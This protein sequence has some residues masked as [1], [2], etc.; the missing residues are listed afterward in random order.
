MS[1]YHSPRDSVLHPVVLVALV[2]WLVN[3]HLLKAAYPGVVTGKLSDVAGLV[4]FPMILLATLPSRLTGGE[5]A[6]PAACACA[7][8]T[9]LAFAAINLDAASARVLTPAFA[10][11]RRLV[12]GEPPG[13]WLGPVRHVTDAEDLLALPFVIVT[14]MIVARRS[15]R[16]SLVALAAVFTAL[17]AATPAHAQDAAA[18]SPSP[19]T[20][21]RSVVRIGAEAFGG[22]T[23]A[24]E[25]ADRGRYSYVLSGMRVGVSAQRGRTQFGAFGTFVNGSLAR[26][27][28][29]YAQFG[30]VHPTYRAFAVG[31]TAGTD[32]RRLR[33]E[34]SLMFVQARY[35]HVRGAA[36]FGNATLRMAIGDRRR[37][38]YSF[39]A[40]SSDGFL[41]DGRLVDQ[42]ILFERD[43]CSVRVAVGAGMVLTPDIAAS[44][45]TDEGW[46]LRASR[47]DHEIIFAIP[48]FIVDFEAHVHVTPRISLDVWVQGGMQWPRGRFGLRVAL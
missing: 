11:L 2:A 45:A 14:P 21:A 10:L 4:A 12:H 17:F 44:V 47:R 24:T 48:D 39:Q 28:A 27:P 29:S 46:R 41:T 25:E 19:K 18:P 31:L 22:A 15:A 8:A 3:D 43:R 7:I 26:V 38:A 32:R 5:R 36:R 42:G 9:A 34:G 30:E 23:L 1:S 33:I 6:L 35:P 13:A 37:A 40:G 20:H 16:A